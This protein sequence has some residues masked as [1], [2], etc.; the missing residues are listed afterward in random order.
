MNE[1]IAEL[2]KKSLKLSMEEFGK[3]IGI[4]KSAVN[5]IEKGVNNPS[6]QT[7]SLICREFNVNEPWLRIGEGEPFQKRTRNQELAEFLNDVMEDAD[8]SFKKRFITALSKLNNSDWEIL[9]KIADEL[10]KED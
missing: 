9:K 10:S 5:Q 4:S 6:E 8:D 7:I 2:R 3:R 1:R